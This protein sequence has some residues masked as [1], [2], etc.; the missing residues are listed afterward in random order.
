MAKLIT[1]KKFRNQYN[2]DPETDER[3]NMF[4]QKSKTVPNMAVSIQEIVNKYTIPNPL[5]ELED[6]QYDNEMTAELGD[7]SM[8]S[9]IEIA[10][11]IQEQTEKIEQYEEQVQYLQEQEY[12][13]QQEAKAQSMANKIIAEHGAKQQEKSQEKI[14]T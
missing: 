13:K 8:L 2:W 3:K 11:R 7:L 10:D 14:T 12:L 5:K 6:E 4:T 1:T 9:Q